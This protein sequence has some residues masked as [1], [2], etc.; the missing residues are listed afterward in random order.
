MSIIS[1]CEMGYWQLVTSSVIDYEVFRTADI[2]RIE[3]I[4]ALC[5]LSKEYLE[6]TPKE[7]EKAQKFQQY[8]IKPMDSFHLALA[9]SFEVDV[10]LTTDKKFLNIAK[11]L[12]LSVRVENPVI[13]FMEV[14][15]NE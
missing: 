9:E 2:A 13:W 8:G 3:D 11:R 1:Y 7:E 12:N 14:M 4:K 10:L 6:L 15:S 5:L